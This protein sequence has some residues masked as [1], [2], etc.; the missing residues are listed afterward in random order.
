MKQSV[1]N[2]FLLFAF[3][4]SNLSGFSQY[5]SRSETLNFT[6]PVICAGGTITLKVFQIQNLPAGSQVQVLLSNP[7]GGF[8]TGTSTLNV[9][10]YSTNQG[11]TWVNGAY[12]F[13]NNVSD[14]FIRA[15]IPAVATPS[16]NYTLKIR[17]S[18]GYVSND[19]FQCS[20]GNF[21]TV[22][23]PVTPLPGVAQNSF[24]INQWFGHVY[25]WVPTTGSLLSTP[26]LIAQQSFFA[27]TNYQGHVVI[28]SL[29]FDN[30]FANTGG[31]PG[32]Q[33]DG[34]SIS[35]G[36]DLS[37]N[38]SVRYMRRHNFA[39]GLYTFNI[40]SDDGA[41][42]SI[43][44]GTTWIL[45]SFIEQNYA[46]SAKT[47]ATAFPQGICLSGDVD[48]VLEYFQRPAQARV[49]INVTQ[50]TS[51]FSQPFNQTICAGQNANFSVGNQNASLSY[52]WQ[53]STDGG[54]TWNNITAAPPYSG[55]T[56]SNLSIANTPAGFH[57]YQYRCLVS[58]TTCAV[59]IPSNAATLNVTPSA[60][61]VT[62][63]QSVSFCNDPS[64]QFSLSA[65]SGSGITY[66]WQINT[67]S[68]FSNITNNT[69]YSGA[70]SATLTVNNPTAS[71]IGHQFQCI[72][73]A[74]GN[75][76]TSVIVT[77]NPGTSVSITQQPQSVSVCAGSGAFFNVALNGVANY[78]WQIN[79]GSGFQN[80]SETSPYSGISTPNLTISPVGNALNGAQIRCVISGTCNGDINSSIAILTVTPI[81]LIT[82]QPADQ[83]VCE[84]I[85][86]QFNSSA[87]NA[88]TYQWMYS[89]DGGTTFLP[90][91]DIPGQVS[92]SQGINLD[93]FNVT[94]AQSGWLIYNAISNACGTV[95][96]NIANLVVLSAPQITS[97][98]VDLTLCQGESGSMQISP[99]VN[100]Q[101][102]NWQWTSN[103][104]NFVSLNSVNGFSGVNTATLQINATSI[105]PGVYTIRVLINSCG[106]SELSQ[107]AILT[108]LSKPSFTLQPEDVYICGNQTATFSI[109][110]QNSTS[111]QW[112]IDNGNGFVNLQNN[113]TVSGATTTT[114]TFTNPGSEYVG[115]PIRC[116]ATGDCPGLYESQTAIL[117]LIAAP[118][119]VVSPVDASVCSG[120]AVTFSISYDGFAQEIFW[121]IST[122]NGPF[123]NIEESGNFTG[124]QSNQLTINNTETD[125]NG[126]VVRCVV[127]GCGLQSFSLPAKLLV[128]ANNP[129]YIPNSFSPNGDDVNPIFKIYTEGKVNMTGHIV[130]RWGEIVF[131]WSDQDK[132]WDGTFNGVD[133]PDG[134]Y[135]YRIYVRTE[136]EVRTEYGFVNVI[137]D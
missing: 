17:S 52:Q 119:I 93:L 72:V 62:Q 111:L 10:Q 95:N 131:S 124:T 31:I 74:C 69:T 114:I 127:K 115:K 133:V 77:I 122:N 96:T 129:V 106:L 108:V 4:I 34:T 117:Q 78:Q 100:G 101:F 71:M 51:L 13:T 110:V 9:T 16:A 94:P 120:K 11:A 76:T 137:K 45:D 23:A 5:I 65:G 54:V 116:V 91:N 25:S 109:N 70:T 57:Q 87:S 134:L 103:P 14:L 90:F 59:S 15:S 92:G 80:L 43:D 39:A 24:G 33:H 19:L 37:T 53:V 20:S 64:L 1:P 97:Q 86:V 73:T 128:A 85:S 44:G 30:N 83:S 82:T 79:T 63:P 40:A 6:C 12:T 2:F 55:S 28:N 130:N 42:L 27:P 84:S 36:N 99:D 123:V 112:Q 49:T 60:N 126:A 21:F 121:Q 136:C 58:S 41:R 38:F 67:G 61:I 75:S 98:P 50:N 66:Q 22:T 35:C 8:A 47:T 88:L 104:P 125:F 105:Q 118:V 26:A 48:L 113:T 56:T 135:A 132:G 102:Y 107:N 68:G 81:P 46:S 89:T 7:T 29:S 32:V 18:S 3:L